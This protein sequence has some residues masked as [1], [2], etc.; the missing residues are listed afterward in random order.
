MTDASRM[1][2]LQ[3]HDC[4]ICGKS[5][6]QK[7]VLTSFIRLKNLIWLDILTIVAF[8]EISKGSK[9]TNRAWTVQNTVSIV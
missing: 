3:Q 4:E 5:Y 7:K 2:F 1:S 6:A 8:P 9:F